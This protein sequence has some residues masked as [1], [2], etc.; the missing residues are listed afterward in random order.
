MA[1]AHVG[2]EPVRDDVPRTVSGGDDVRERAPPAADEDS[3]NPGNNLHISSLSYDAQTEDLERVFAPYGPLSKVQVM[4]DPHTGEAR[5]F[6]FVT[7]EN[8]EDAE[9]AIAELDQHEVLGRP[10]RVQ[11][12]RRA[13]AHAPTP[14]QYRGTEGRARRDGADGRRDGFRGGFRGSG[15]GYRRDDGYRRDGGYRR[16]DRRDDRRDGSYRRDDRRD[17][18]FR[19]DERRD[20]AYRRDDRRDEGYRRDERR[21]GRR[22]D[23]YRRDD[24]Y[25]RDDRRDD[26]RQR[27]PPPPVRP[28]YEDR[29]PPNDA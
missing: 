24:S 19:R 21:D 18:G 8:V 28:A 26:R 11:K 17:E 9:R 7:F 29:A 6:G 25:R 10:I 20:D 2:A 13:R 22:D 27:S 12:A 23:G 5:G 4:R 16:D 15:G 3:S 14:G 1:G